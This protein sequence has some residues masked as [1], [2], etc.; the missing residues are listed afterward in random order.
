VLENAVAANNVK[1][2]IA[3]TYVVLVI[4]CCVLGKL[5][6]IVTTKSLNPRATVRESAYKKEVYEYYI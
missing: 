2:N 3:T 5:E 6:K 4:I 1:P